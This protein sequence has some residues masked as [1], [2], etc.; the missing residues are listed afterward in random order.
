MKRWSIVF[1]AIFGFVGCGD[2][3]YVHPTKTAQDLERDQ[4]DCRKEFPLY[5]SNMG[6]APVIHVMRDEM[7]D[8]LRARGWTPQEEQEVNP[9]TKSKYQQ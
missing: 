2:R 9:A 6:F 5:V 7:G 3:V 4:Y 8:C 1:I